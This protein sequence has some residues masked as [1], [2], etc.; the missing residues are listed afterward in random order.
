MR[1]LKLTLLIAVLLSACEKD[2]DIITVSSL[3][4]SELVA[5]ITSIVLEQNS[6]VGLTLAWSKSTLNIS[7]TSVAVPSDIP[8]MVL[9]ISSSDEF[10]LVT[11]VAADD[12]AKSFAPA[13]LNTIATDLGFE[14]YKSAPLYLRVAANLGDNT[15]PV[16]SNVVVVNVSTYTID[17]SMGIILDSERAETGLTLFSSN[18]DG[19]YCGF[20][21]AKAWYG[22][23]LL[24]GDGVIWGNYAVDGY[25]FVLDNEGDAANIWNCWYPGQTGCYYTTFSTIDKVWTATLIPSLA[26]SGDVTAD[27]TYNQEDNIWS[28]S[29]TTTNDNATFSVNG[30]S[31]LYNT[32]TSTDDASAITGTVTFAPDGD[33]LLLYNQS[34]AFTVSGAA[35]NY[36][37]NIKLE[38]PKSWT[39]EITSGTV[40]VEDPISEYLY[41]PGIDDGISGSWTFD[42]YLSLLSAEDSTF[43]G[44]VNVSTLWGYHMGLEKDNWTDVYKMTSGD[45]YSGSLGFQEGENI[46]VPDAGVYLMKA[47]LSQLTYDLTALGDSIYITGLNDVWDFT[48]DV[49]TETATSGT[50]SG[51]VTISGS[52]PYGYSILLFQDDWNTKFGGSEGA[53]IFGGGNITAAWYETPGTY[54][55]TVDLINQICTVE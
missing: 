24:E 25:S 37:F 17:M 31:S 10:T 54:T 36:T 49:L 12:Y 18:S 32:T 20:I 43:A 5:N 27:M 41:L 38:N 23:Y 53:L 33:S 14:P 4:S 50:Y 21:G 51:T 1:I 47:D 19:E 11:E 48:T 6:T 2:G 55:M 29:F 22:Y 30:L 9:Q 35:G 3:S 16:Y 28:A 44:V 52:T 7:D 45:A 15:E 8:A 34:G 42:N 46:S 39:Y 26:I 40:V 13:E